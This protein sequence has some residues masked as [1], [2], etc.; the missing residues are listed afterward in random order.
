MQ[1]ACN[2]RMLTAFLA[3]LLDCMRASCQTIHYCAHNLRA[4]QAAVQV[5]AWP[6]MPGS[7]V[8]LAGAAAGVVMAIILAALAVW[9]F[10]RK[11]RHRRAEAPLQPEGTIT[12]RTVRLS[13]TSH[14]NL[15][16]CLSI[17]ESISGKCSLGQDGTARDLFKV[18]GLTHTKQSAM[19]MHFGSCWK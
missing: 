1:V 14:A 12:G 11:R 17:S 6:M 18:A 8:S 3:D 5:R 15:S 16:L 2:Q 13:L 9:Y 10:V 7:G 19:P 4:W